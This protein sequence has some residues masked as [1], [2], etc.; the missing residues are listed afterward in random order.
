MTTKFQYD[1]F[2]YEAFAEERTLLQKFLPDTIRAGFAPETIQEAGHV[3]PVAQVISLRTQSKIPENWAGQLQAILS[4]STGY[5]HLLDY[6]ERTGFQGQMG[7]LP[8]YCN[9]AVAEQAMLLWMTLLRKL[10]LQFKQFNTFSRD[11]L[12]GTE[13]AG[14]TLLVVGVGNIGYQ[15]VR[16]GRGLDMTVLGVD[17]V[18]KFDD[19]TY[20]DVEHGLAQADIVVAAMNLTKQNRGY[21][22][23]DLLKKAKP[24]VIFINIARGEL[25]PL[26]DLYWLVKEKQ[27]GGLA[28][29]VF[30]NESKLAIAFRSGDIDESDSYFKMIRELQA[31][32]NVIFTPHNAFNTEESVVR[33]ARHSVQQ[34]EHLFKEG[35]FLW[36]IPD[37]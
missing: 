8:L 3:Q 12:T 24:G 19:V 14:K 9:R 33:K 34:L 26:Q 35:H 1:V 10:P 28:L 2:F 37:A 20:V 25:S 29:D 30:E 4:R 13:C 22:H 36:T 31:L 32:P 21:F 18:Q 23:Y 16:I 6:K 15:V 11:G 5:N 7:Y 27:I 17:I